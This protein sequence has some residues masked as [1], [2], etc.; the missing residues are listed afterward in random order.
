MGTGE[1]E[2]RA[3]GKNM[4]KY[5]G[6]LPLH[7]NESEYR[8]VLRLKT[9]HARA[10]VNNEVS[11]VVARLIRYA[12]ASFPAEG[13]FFYVP[14]PPRTATLHR[15]ESGRGSVLRRYVSPSWQRVLVVFA[16]Y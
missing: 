10:L 13:R 7:V 5:I 4:Q 2:E 8:I 12:G 16:F 9:R 14:P 1:I 3:V 11:V 15:R 6:L